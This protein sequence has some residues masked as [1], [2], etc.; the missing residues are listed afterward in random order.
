MRLRRSTI[1]GGAA[2]FVF[3][4]AGGIVAAT[5]GAALPGKATPPSKSLTVVASNVSGLFPGAGI[6]PVPVTVSNPKKNTGAATIQSITPVLKGDASDGNVQ[7]C[8]IGVDVTPTNRS[9]YDL[10]FTGYRAPASGPGV[11][12]ERDGSATVNL[13]AELINH[14]VNQDDC[15]SV[16]ISLEYVATATGR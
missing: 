3:L 4:F 11:T 7:G 9:Q 1:I 16:T 14:P 2:A 15:K 5:S 6:K 13:A 12:L 10:V 8:R